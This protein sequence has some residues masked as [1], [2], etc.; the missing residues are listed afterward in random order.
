MKVSYTVSTTHS[1]YLN[2]T[3]LLVF[4]MCYNRNYKQSINFIKYL[5]L[6]YDLGLQPATDIWD[7]LVQTND[8][9]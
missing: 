9:Y 8:P 4:K 1:L 7:Y 2:K 5:C 6:R 3:D